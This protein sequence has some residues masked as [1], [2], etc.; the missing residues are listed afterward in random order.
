METKREILSLRT[1]VV[2]DTELE[3]FF[4][5][6]DINT[7]ES[8]IFSI[9]DLS[10]YHRIGKGT[11]FQEAHYWETHKTGQRVRYSQIFIPS[12]EV[13]ESQLNVSINCNMPSC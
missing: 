6:T 13:E 12:M 2:T 8:E 7:Q 4:Y 1:Y 10:K 11:V 9:K 3:E 5:A